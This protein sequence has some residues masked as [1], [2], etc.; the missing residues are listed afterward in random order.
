MLSII[1]NNAKLLFDLSNKVNTNDETLF[2]HH[3][4][5]ENLYY[6]TMIS[7]VMTTSNRSTQTYFT[8]DTINKSLCKDIQVIIVDDST[9]DEIDVSVL[10]KYLFF[11]NYIK[12]KKNNKIWYNPLVN[13]N[14]G[15]KFIKGYIV[16]IQNAEVCHIGDI[17]SFINN[18]VK[19]DNYYVFDVKSSKN[20]ETNNK[21]YCS[22]LNI[23]IYKN[24]RLFSEW[25]QSKQKKTNY[26]FLSCM[27]RDTF[28]KVKNFSY[29]LALGHAYDDNDFLL[30]II[31][32]NI[33]IINIHNDIYKI[34]GIHLYHHF[35][36]IKNDNEL[37]KKIE[38]NMTLFNIKK[39]YYNKYK[40]YIDITNDESY[41]KQ[42]IDKIKN[43]I[44]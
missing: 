42:E 33:N 21:I 35:S 27:T 37:N 18:N 29:D 26:H 11:I 22:E 19:D 32:K 8:L 39:E 12:I 31:S 9:E 5:N 28:N 4:I 15:F 23:N 17:L 40:Y 25:Y 13:Y 2:E 43:Y 34:G 7:I 14:I 41:F 36:G 1:E 24:E 30:K 44:L 20:I 6:D 16:I 10:K 3:I 38:L